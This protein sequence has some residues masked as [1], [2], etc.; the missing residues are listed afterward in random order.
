MKGLG[1]RILS[2]LLRMVERLPLVGDLVNCRGKDFWEALV[3]VFSK[4]IFSLSPI[5]IWAF[6][7]SL[8]EQGKD[9]TILGIIKDTV[10]HGELFLFCT[11]LL[12][13]IFYMA[14][15]E[16]KGSKDFKRRLAI[17]I[18]TVI[19]LILTTIFYISNRKGEPFNT[20]NIFPY[21]VTFYALSALLLYIATVYNNSS[22]SAAEEFQ[23][24][25]NEFAEQYNNHRR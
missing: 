14:L 15:S 11:S 22:R 8:S 4:Q 5:W 10:S 9:K 23:K 2:S 3:E 12:A 16:H 6:Y 25:E 21:S 20:Q 17:I 24:V 13:P 7:M 18:L 1:T 19:I